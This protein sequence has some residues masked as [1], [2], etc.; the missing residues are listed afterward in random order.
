MLLVT[1][2]LQV[3]DAMSFGNTVVVVKACLGCKKG[4]SKILVTPQQ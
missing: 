3:E 2:V 4:V 1:L